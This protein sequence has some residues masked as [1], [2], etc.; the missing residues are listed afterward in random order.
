MIK[1]NRAPAPSELTDEVKTKLTAEFKEDN[2]KRVWSQLYIKTALLQMSN[3][4]CCYCE[5]KIGAGEDEMHVDHYHDKKNYPDEVVEWNNLLP[6]CP[7]CNKK[8]SNHDTYLEPIVNP[9]QDDPKEIFYIHNYRYCSYDCDPNSLGKISIAVLGLNDLEKKIKKRFIIG[10]KLSEDLDRLYEDAIELGDAI[11]TNVR[12]RN[13]IING[14]KNNLKLCTRDSRFGAMM[15]T[16]LQED[17]NY[18]GLRKILIKYEFWDEE[19]E[20]LHKESLEICLM[21]KK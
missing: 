12:K 6:S 2:K 20:N 7:H 15:S 3:G 4:K 10:S 9:T 5:D 8:K 21:K 11:L 13:R 19:L 14:C 18:H 17:D 1:I 16:I